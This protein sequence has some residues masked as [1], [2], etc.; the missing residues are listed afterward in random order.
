MTGSLLGRLRPL[1]SLVEATG[2]AEGSWKRIWEA[3]ERGD[4]REVVA[5]LP[6]TESA[7]PCLE[8]AGILDR[9]GRLAADARDR[10]L[11]LR[12]LMAV[13]AEPRDTWLPVVTVPPFLRPLFDEH[14]ALETQTALRRLV[15]GARSELVVASP[16]LDRGF[17]SLVPAIVRLLG[18]G[19]RC[20]LITRDLL[21]VGTGGRNR[22]VVE[23]LRREARTGGDLEVVSWEE[24]GLGVHMKVVVADSEQAY[25]GSANLTWGGMGRHAEV[26]VLLEGKGVEA[27]RTIMETVAEGIR[28]ERSW[29]AP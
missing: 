3:I 12:I 8:E 26:G 19:G 9:S 11:E 18:A 10:L 16:F 22:E 27:I 14:R 5:C 28:R 29:Q 1:A 23:E 24:A 7:R 21:D 13:R 17:R 15:T 2:D 6:E 25:V 4:P 20:L